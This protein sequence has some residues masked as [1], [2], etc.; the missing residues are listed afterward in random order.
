MKVVENSKLYKNVLEVL[1]AQGDDIEM[2][3]SEVAEIKAHV[4]VQTIWR[5]DINANLAHIL[6]IRDQ[7][8][9][10]HALFMAYF[11]SLADDVKKRE[12]RRT[13]VALPCLPTAV[14]GDWYTILAEQ[15]ALI[16]ASQKSIV[17]DYRVIEDIGTRFKGWKDQS[18]SDSKTMEQ[19]AKEGGIKQGV[20]IEHD[21][22]TPFNIP[23]LCYAPRWDAKKRDKYLLRRNHELK[24]IQEQEKAKKEKELML[25]KVDEFIAA[26]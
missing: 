4:I 25:K 20:W 22:Y 3:K 17:T 8:A 9:N 10:M 14:V 7:V 23:P 18:Y 24:Q 16:Q 15:A 1:K 21:E 5:K 13:I 2:I 19:I 6:I 11:Y 12:E 26:K